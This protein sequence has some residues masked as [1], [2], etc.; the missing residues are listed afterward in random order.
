MKRSQVIEHIGKILL[1][2]YSGMDK[3]KQELYKDDSLAEIILKEL[4]TLNIKLVDEE[5]YITSYEPEEGW[6]RWIEEQDKIDQARDFQVI[7]DANRYTGKYSI[8]RGAKIAQDFLEGQSFEEL[9]DKYNI[10]RER[11]RQIVA[12]YRRRYN[13]WL[14]SKDQVFTMWRY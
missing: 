5:G 8:S 14:E 9:S 10:T 7:V 1:Y 12:K 4:E 13:Q 3:D 6:E 2:G 11:V